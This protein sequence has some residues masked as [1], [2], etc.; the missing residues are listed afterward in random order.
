MKLVMLDF[1]RDELKKLLRRSGTRAEGTDTPP[2]YVVNTDLP[3][4]Y[5]LCRAFLY[6]SLRESFGIPRPGGNGL[7]NTGD[8]LQYLF[9][10]GDRRSSGLAC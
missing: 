1:D 2:G 4:L 10:A 3:A 7:R 9:D 6:P 8:H 5:S